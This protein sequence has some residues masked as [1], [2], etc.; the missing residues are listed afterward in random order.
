MAN[1]HF[2][3]FVESLGESRQNPYLSRQKF[4]GDFTLFCRILKKGR[5]NPKLTAT[6]GGPGSK[7]AP[8]LSKQPRGI[9][10]YS[11]REYG[12][13]LAELYRPLSRSIARLYRAIWRVK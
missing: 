6:S 10:P 11:L 13:F 8:F 4:L 12:I 2:N 5:Q 3:C 9:L 7:K 1:L